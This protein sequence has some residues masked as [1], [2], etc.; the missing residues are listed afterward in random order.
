MGIAH[1]SYLEA[2]AGKTHLVFIPT[3]SMPTVEF[4]L[5]DKKG[6][7]LKETR[8]MHLDTGC[9]VNLI[10]RKAF[11]TDFAKL[12]PDVVVYRIRPFIVSLADGKS[13]AVT[14][15]LVDN[16]WLAIG[17]AFYPVFSLIVDHLTQDYLIGM[18][19]L[20]M[21]RSNLQQKNLL[22]GSQRKI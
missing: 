14:M 11:N 8:D 12:G 13:H 4:K 5:T 15:Q 6:N 20:Y 17:Q 16:A 2:A 1:R 9:N 21:A 22:L 18:P 19:F 3:A 7:V 10:S